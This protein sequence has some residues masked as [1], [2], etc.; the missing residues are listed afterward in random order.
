MVLLILIIWIRS[1]KQ[2]I[3]W[4]KEESIENGAYPVI[5]MQI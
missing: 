5:H 2:L 1:L 3:K 4:S